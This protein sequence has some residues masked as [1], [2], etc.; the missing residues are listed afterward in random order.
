[1]VR[2]IFKEKVVFG[3]NVRRKFRVDWLGGVSI[4]YVS[5]VQVVTVHDKNASIFG[6]QYLDKYRVLLHNGIY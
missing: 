2:V 6:K 1:M 5:R 3:G 4:H